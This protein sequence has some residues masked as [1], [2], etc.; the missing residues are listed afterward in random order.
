MF[1]KWIILGFCLTVSVAF[2]QQVNG[3]DIRHLQRGEVHPFVQYYVVW[4]LDIES[5]TVA[6]QS[7]A[8]DC[9]FTWTVTKGQFNHVK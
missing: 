4:L 7:D 6:D 3:A 5:R 9:R 2:A 1:T 8:Q